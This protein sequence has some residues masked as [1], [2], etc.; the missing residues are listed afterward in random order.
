[1]P[2]ARRGRFLDAGGRRCPG[3]AHSLSREGAA[4]P[5]TGH[6]GHPTYEQ[7]LRKRDPYALTRQSNLCA[8]SPLSWGRRARR[9]PVL[10][11]RRNDP[12]LVVGLD[13]EGRERHGHAERDVIALGP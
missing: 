12:A 4:T 13:G 5:A 7:R 6:N 2:R 1:M 11:D 9:A 3:H 10:E 8:L